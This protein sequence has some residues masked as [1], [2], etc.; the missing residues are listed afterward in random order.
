M[1]DS[2]RGSVAA[3]VAV[4]VVIAVVVVVVVGGRRECNLTALL[5]RVTP[6]LTYM[7]RVQTHRG[8]GGEV[9]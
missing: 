6:L 3:V 4:A 9:T 8:R 5:L 2:D 1:R 7:E